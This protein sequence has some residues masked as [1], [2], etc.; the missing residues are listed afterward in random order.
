MKRYF[1]VAAS[2]IFTIALFAQPSVGDTVFSKVTTKQAREQR[3][4]Y[5]VD[6]TIKQY[7]SDPLND[8]NEG[9]WND[10]LWGIELLQYKDDYTKQKLG[11]AWSKAPQMS[12]YF[13]KNL[14]ETTYSLYK[15][16]F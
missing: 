4:K 9:E 7:L 13:Q 3:Y 15:K 2:F 12:E 16:E 11:V 8:D 1:L 14:L 5:L 6:T 10:A